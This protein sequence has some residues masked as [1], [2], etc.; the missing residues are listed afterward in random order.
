MRPTTLILCFYR[1]TLSVSSPD[2]A[3]GDEQC[4]ISTEHEWYYGAGDLVHGLGSWRI[5]SSSDRRGVICEASS[6]ES[7]RG[8]SPMVYNLDPPAVG[9]GV[10]REAGGSGSVPATSRAVV[11]TL[12]A[13]AVA[14]AVEARYYER[15]IV[16]IR[17]PLCRTNLPHTAPQSTLCSRKKMLNSTGFAAPSAPAAA[18]VV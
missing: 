13:A 12:V 16:C 8:A 6:V 18:A 4:R 14:A 2:C 3:L 15:H 7:I 9:G 1:L 11:A 10:D 17:V 5:A